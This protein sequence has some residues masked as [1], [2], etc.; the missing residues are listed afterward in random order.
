MKN[1][2]DFLTILT[3]GD[4]GRKYK[5]EIIQ[6]CLIFSQHRCINCEHFIY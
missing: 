4:L 2:T 5:W 3:I 6:L 1:S